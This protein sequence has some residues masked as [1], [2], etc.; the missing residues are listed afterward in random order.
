M[1]RFACPTTLASG[2]SHSRSLETFSENLASVDKLALDEWL[3]A[4]APRSKVEDPNL[5]YGGRSPVSGRSSDTVE[6]AYDR[7]RGVLKVEPQIYITSAKS[8]GG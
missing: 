5:G 6:F 8:F 4:E 3:K 7:N 1:G 2:S